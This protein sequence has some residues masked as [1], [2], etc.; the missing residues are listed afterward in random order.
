MDIEGA[1]V[2]ADIVGE[3]LAL[4]GE[5]AYLY[6]YEPNYVIREADCTAGN[7]MLFVMGDNG[8]KRTATYWGARLLTESWAQPADAKLEIYPASANVVTRRGR[9][10]VTAYALRRPEG[11]WSVLLINKDPQHDWPVRV[12]IRDTVS[13]SIASMRGPVDLVQFSPAEYEWS[14]KAGM[15]IKSEPPAR[16]VVDDAIK[17]IVL[18][19]YSLTVVRG[20]N[21]P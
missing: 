6:G 2:N 21:G 11:S 3:F 8:I 4:G 14:A 17:E 5:Q 18:P 1:L 10:L 15:P 16:S 13:G 20:L 19:A 12:Q 9:P 7:N